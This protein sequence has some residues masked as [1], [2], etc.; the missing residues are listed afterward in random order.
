[1]IYIFDTNVIIDYLSASM[2]PTAMA[3]MHQIVNDGF[4]I[5]VISKIESLGFDSGNAAV[6]AN[7]AA[8]VSLGT[9]FELTP[10]IVQQTIDLKR[11]KKIKTPDGI[12]AATALVHNLTL[13][14]RNAKD[15]NI[16][17][18][19]FIDPHSL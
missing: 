17:G 15:F 12:I 4:F 18:L 11:V 19:T 3:A 13:L 9:V 8:F 6:D 16:Q 10:D 7:T 5:S 1:M 14:T 2:P